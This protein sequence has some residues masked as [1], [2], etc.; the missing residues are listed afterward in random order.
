MWKYHI[1]KEVLVQIKKVVEVFMF[2]KRK[3]RIALIISLIATLFITTVVSS[4]G[5]TAAEKLKEANEAKKK[6]EAAEES[7][8]EMEQRYNELDIEIQNTKTEIYETKKDIVKKEKQIEKQEKAL[9]QRLTAMYKTG[10]VGFVDV[11]LS[12]Q[13]IQDLISNLGMVQKVLGNDQDILRNLQKDLKE[14]AKL[15]KDLEVKE[16]NLSDRQEEVEELR[17]SYRKAVKKY[18][19]K[20]EQLRAEAEQLAAQASGSS[21]A[22]TGQYTPTDFGTYMWPTPSNWF[23][24]SYFGWRVH[25]IL[26]YRKYHNGYDIVLTS[27]T[28]GAPL[29]AVG[30]GYVSMASYYGGYGNC[31][32][33]NIGNGYTV[34][35]GHLNGYNVS[36]GQTVKKGDVIGYIGSTGMSTGP[37]LHF[38]LLKNGEYIDPLILYQ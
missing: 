29:Y 33:I 13:S 19:A 3:L 10:T 4:Y 38:S 27:G 12:S 22:G 25:P 11:I 8:E 32:M 35:Y 21:G 37:H 1:Y 16:Q 30:N 18:E 5:A 15:K 14:L 17:E 36:V 6:K 23:Y 9:N 2:R 31:V 7:M 20:E 28:F 24:T 26:G 34:L